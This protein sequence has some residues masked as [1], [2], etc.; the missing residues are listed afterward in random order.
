MPVPV[1]RAIMN[2][3]RSMLMPDARGFG[4]NRPIFV[5]NAARRPRVIG[6]RENR[7]ARHRRRHQCVFVTSFANFPG[8]RHKKCA[9]KVVAARGIQG[10]SAVACNSEKICHSVSQFSPALLM[11]CKL[12]AESF[13][14]YAIFIYSFTKAESWFLKAAFYMDLLRIVRNRKNIKDIPKISPLAN[15]PFSHSGAVILTHF[16]V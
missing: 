5:E 9:F 8:G 11:G 14:E 4:Q 3:W 2:F 16:I 15:K 13:Y 12:L 10:I 7:Y 1:L 6:T